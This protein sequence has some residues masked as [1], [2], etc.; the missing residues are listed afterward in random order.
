MPEL[1]KLKRIGQ[2]PPLTKRER[3]LRTR[4]GKFKAWVWYELQTNLCLGLEPE[5][6]VRLYRILF[7]DKAIDRP[8]AMLILLETQKTALVEGREVTYYDTL[9]LRRVPLALQPSEIRRRNEQRE[10]VFRE[11]REWK[12]QGRPKD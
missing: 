6:V 4:I 7:G 10:Q 11:Y 8:H 1:R 5:K 2:P 3:N 12:S 9:R